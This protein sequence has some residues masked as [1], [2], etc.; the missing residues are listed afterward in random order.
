MNKGEY[1]LYAGFLVA[2]TIN[3]I[4]GI[5]ICIVGAIISDRTTSLYLIGNGDK[6]K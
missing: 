1:I 5:S 3:S 4:L 2:V 6:K